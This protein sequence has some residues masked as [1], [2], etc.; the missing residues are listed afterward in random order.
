MWEMLLVGAV[1]P[2]RSELTGPASS[3]AVAPLPLRLSPFQLPS[4]VITGACGHPH[5]GRHQQTLPG[6]PAQGIRARRTAGAP[7]H[8]TVA[9]PTAGWH[10]PASSSH[11][12]AAGGASVSRVGDTVSPAAFATGSG[13][14][15][16]HDRRRPTSTRPPSV[17]LGEQTA[18]AGGG[19]CSGTDAPPPPQGT[20]ATH[21]PAPKRRVQYGTPIQLWDAR[22]R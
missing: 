4:A 14:G 10:T 15:G 13:G 21:P 9:A 6:G 11:R 1:R 18:S 16:G 22:Q 5:A 20:A 2:Y 19:G 8:A 3:A 12:L 7:R 17:G